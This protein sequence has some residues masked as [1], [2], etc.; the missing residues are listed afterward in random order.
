MPVGLVEGA[1]GSLTFKIIENIGE[2]GFF[3]DVRSDGEGFGVDG[4]RAA[5]DQLVGSGGRERREIDGG[6]LPILPMI[7]GAVIDNLSV[8]DTLVGAQIDEVEGHRRKAV[9]CD[10]DGAFGLVVFVANLVGE[11]FGSLTLRPEAEG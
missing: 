1:G 2:G 3:E 4:S 8:I 7:D 6:E 5:D 11:N 9:G 10:E